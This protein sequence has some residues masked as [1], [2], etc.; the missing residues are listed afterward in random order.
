[1]DKFHYF[2]LNK[3]KECPWLLSPDTV[4][5]KEACQ[6]ENKHVTGKPHLEFD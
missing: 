2:L 5:N 6:E 3:C 1:M 4:D